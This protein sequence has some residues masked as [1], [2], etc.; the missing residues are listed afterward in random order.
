VSDG[1]AE[2]SSGLQ[3]AKGAYRDKRLREAIHAETGEWRQPEPA[4]ALAFARRLLRHIE[5]CQRFLTELEAD[6][7]EVIEAEG[8]ELE[9]RG[10]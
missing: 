10:A 9:E 7:Q 8:W 4:A 3:R 5:A 1:W 6:S 2:M